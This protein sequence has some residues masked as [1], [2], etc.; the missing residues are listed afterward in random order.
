MAFPRSQTVLLWKEVAGTR[1][2]GSPRAVSLS[3]LVTI[4]ILWAPDPAHDR[5]FAA[6]LPMIHLLPFRRAPVAL[7]ELSGED[8][9]LQQNL[10]CHPRSFSPEKLSGFSM[11]SITTDYEYLSEVPSRFPEM[12]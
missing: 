7:A 12:A 8:R 2:V 10:P 9:R 11:S 5:G 6:P 4:Y 1:K 3:G